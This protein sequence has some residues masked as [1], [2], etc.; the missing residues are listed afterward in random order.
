MLGHRPGKSAKHRTIAPGQNDHATE[1]PGEDTAKPAN[2]HE[3]GQATGIKKR[4]AARHDPREDRR[5]ERVLAE[6]L[7]EQRIGR[8]MYEAPVGIKGANTT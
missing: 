3:R 7:P 5:D 4:L 6:L 8:F 2:D 1:S